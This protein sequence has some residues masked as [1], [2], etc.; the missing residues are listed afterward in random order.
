LF[1]IR[2]PHAGVTA[3][4]FFMEKHCERLHASDAEEDQHM[5]CIRG[6]DPA[7]YLE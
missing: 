7:E 4:G 1:V 3:C 6:T 2:K 5:R